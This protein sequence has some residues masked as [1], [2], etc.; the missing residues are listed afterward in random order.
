MT[1]ADTINQ[2]PVLVIQVGTPVAGGHAIVSLAATASANANYG[3][4]LGSL[5][6]TGNKTAGYTTAQLTGL[7]ASTGN[8]NTSAWAA[9][10][11]P[12]IYGVDVEVGGT[13]ATP[14]QIAALIAAIDTGDGVAPAS[15]GVVASATDPS[16]GDL[17]GLN[18]AGTTYNLFLDFAAGGP[19]IPLDNLGLDLSSS[20]DSL[21]AG[22][23]FTAVSVVPE[24][25]SLGLL[26][27]GGLGL[28]S[29]RN[30]RKA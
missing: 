14:T 29:R 7:S 16:G 8:V 18:G 24:P 9:T 3:S 28:M 30:R 21:L 15:T 10:T 11:D 23:T 26:A 13:Q 20:N 1:A 22:Y 12:E 2:L 4:T 6:I 25:M 5:T 17:S 19:S 27:L